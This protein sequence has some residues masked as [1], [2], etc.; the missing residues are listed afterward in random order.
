MVNREYAVRLAS[1]MV[2]SIALSGL[3]LTLVLFGLFRNR[4]SVFLPL[5]AVLIAITM[6]VGYMVLAG[7]SFDIINSIVPTL[8][9]VIG[10]GDAVHF[11]T[12]YYQELGSG[13][14]KQL[15][16]KRMVK[17]IGAACFLTSLTAAIGFASLLV[18]RIDIIKGMGR[19]AA[20]GLMISYLVI[21]LLV[22]A[23]LSLAEAPRAAVTR[24]LDAGLLGRLLRWTANQVIERKAAIV[25]LTLGII[26]LSILGGQR[27]ETNN[28]LLEELFDDNPV[29]V[30]LHHTQDVLTGVM[31]IEIS[32]HATETDDAGNVSDREF[33]V[34]EPDVLRPDDGGGVHLVAV[35]PQ[36]DLLRLREVSP[37]DE[38][39]VVDAPRRPLNLQ[40]VPQVGRQ[41][42][43]EDLK[44]SGDGWMD[45]WRRKSARGHVAA[46]GLFCPV[47]VL[48]VPSSS[49]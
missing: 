20:I 43:Q 39:L 34:L 23:V 25:A 33:G 45:E 32:I 44:E 10:I 16:I 4:Y 27:V 11:L 24:D 30:A 38:A 12:T 13:E 15:A 21:L 5:T 40:L 48:S 35:Q 49:L 42:A 41:V 6:T 7:D 18:A 26:V 36:Q 19:V 14:D 37:V 31:P 1:D 2:Q 3:L 46:L 22:P 9:L 8:L 28:F 47:V 29:S 17:R